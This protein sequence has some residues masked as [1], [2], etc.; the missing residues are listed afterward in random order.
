MLPWVGA[1][2]R[3]LKTSR[4]RGRG[5][6]DQQQWDICRLSGAGTECDSAVLAFQ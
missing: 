5:W 2:P 1:V 6:K 4:D 3:C